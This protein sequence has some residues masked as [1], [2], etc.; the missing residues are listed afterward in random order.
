MKHLI[1]IPLSILTA[2]FVLM[3]LTLGTFLQF[4][5]YNWFGWIMFVCWYT[6]AIAL[7]YKLYDAK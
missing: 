1:V 6:L 5:K 2:T 3:A 4:E 7:G